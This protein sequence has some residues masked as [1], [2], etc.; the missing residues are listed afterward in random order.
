MVLRHF[1]F[2]V[3]SVALS[4]LLCLKQIKESSD[5]VKL[6]HFGQFFAAGVRVLFALD[7]AI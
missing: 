7:G 6:R 3:V 2:R 5:P 4:L 1:H